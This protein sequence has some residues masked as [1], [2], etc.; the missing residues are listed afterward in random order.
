MK[1][2]LSCCVAFSLAFWA[3]GDDSSSGSGS[4]GSGADTSGK[5]GLEMTSKCLDNGLGVLY[6]KAGSDELDKAYLVEDSTGNNQILV[7][8]LNDYCDIMADFKSKRLGD[9]LEIWFNLEDAAVT[10]CMCA[11]D[12]LFDIKTEDADAKYFKYSGDVFVVTSE[13]APVR[14]EIEEPVIPDAPEFDESEPHQE[15]TD[16]I[17][18]CDASPD[19]NENLL[20]NKFRLV[21]SWDD[22]TEKGSDGEIIPYARTHFDG[23]DVVLVFEATFDC[24][25]KVEKVNV[26]PSNDTLYAKT[27]TSVIESVKL[28]PNEGCGCMTRAAFKLKNEGAYAEAKYMVF[29]NHMEY[30]YTIAEGSEK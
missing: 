15:V 13:P 2:F 26:Y 9:T 29:D 20:S 21:D 23:D 4:N 7:P 6:K 5:I 16:V 27:E 28:E 18:Y 17:G 24:D 10:N 8:E 25:K 14:P 1:K 22:F 11:K 30:V 19:E 3:C 12:H